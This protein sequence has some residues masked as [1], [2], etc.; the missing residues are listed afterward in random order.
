ML[1]APLISTKID[2]CVSGEDALE[3]VNDFNP[4]E[5]LGGYPEEPPKRGLRARLLQWWRR[6]RHKPNPEDELFD[7]AILQACAFVDLLDT[8]GGDRAA[9]EK[10]IEAERSS[11]PGGDRLGWIREAIKKRERRQ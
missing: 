11:L 10:L 2:R 8:M 3:P 6:F 1:A 7:K 9:T 5:L 4:G